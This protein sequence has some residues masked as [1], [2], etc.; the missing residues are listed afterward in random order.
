MK[1]VLLPA[2]VT[3]LFASEYITLDNGK[4]I[5]LKDDGTWQEV[6][7]VKKGNETI[8][9]KPDGTWE[10][11]EAKRIETANKLETAADKK[12]KD[13]PL[14]RKLIGKWEGDGIAYTFTPDNATLKIKEGNRYKTISGKWKVE[15]VDKSKKIVTVN[16]SEGMRLGPLSFGGEIRKLQIDGDQLVDLTDRFDGKVYTLNKVR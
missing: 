8:A 13:S 6:Q 3:A 16:I 1:R 11:I 15:N 12:F 14:V 10:K 9:I 2:I 5:M 7:V 4:V